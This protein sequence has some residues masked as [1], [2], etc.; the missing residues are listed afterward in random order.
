MTSKRLLRLTTYNIPTTRNDNRV[1]EIEV[2]FFLKI[3]KYKP[4]NKTKNPI[5]K[6]I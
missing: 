5:P 1:E 2:Y 4:L 6:N 3:Y